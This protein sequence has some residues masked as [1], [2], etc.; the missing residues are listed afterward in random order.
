MTNREFKSIL[1][2]AFTSKGFKLVDKNARYDGTAAAIFVGLQKLEYDEQYF[3][4]VGFWLRALGDQA[5]R[6]VEQTHMYFRLERL[7]PNLRETVLDG[8]R[9][10]L[11]DQPQAATA[12]S[13]II[14]AE[15]IPVLTELANSDLTLR[16]RFREGGFS[17]GL[18]RKEAREALAAE[19]FPTPDSQ[20]STPRG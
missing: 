7:F 1:E 20:P 13:A 14:S 4:N 19:T 2:G 11:P 18:I 3:I 8:G 9:L 17:G 15:C 10:S 12:L 5:P 6:K 16:K